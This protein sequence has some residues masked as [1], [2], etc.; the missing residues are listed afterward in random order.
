VSLL[1]D[2][3]MRSLACTAISPGLCSILVFD[4]TPGH[5][6]QTAQVYSQM[7]EVAN[8]C[9]VES[10]TLA[11]YETDDE[12]WGSFGLCGK[13]E[14]QL[15]KWKQGLLTASNN[16]SKLKLVIIPDLTRLSLAAARACVVLM[17]AETAHLER[18]GQQ[19]QWKPNLCWLAACDTIED[20]CQ[21]HR[22]KVGMVSPHLLDRFAIRLVGEVVEKPDRIA[23][24]KEL[25]EIDSSKGNWE[26]RKLQALPH[27]FQLNLKRALQIYPTIT[28]SVL[29]RILDYAWGIEV[30][31]PRRE[32]ALAR[33][34]IANARLLGALAVTDVHVDIAA[35]MIGLQ[36]SKQAQKAANLNSNAITPVEVVEPI[37]TEV[38]SIEKP[39]IITASEPIYE[40]LEQEVLPPV[41]IPIDYTSVNPYP[42][43]EA[44]IE[45]EV[46]SLR[47]PSGSFKLQSA[48]RG[49]IVGVEK[50]TTLH[51]LAL[52]R[53]L[54][55]A[56]K[57]Q[58]I[59]QE[60]TNSQKNGLRQ[61]VLSPKDFY[62]YRRSPVAQQMLMLLIDHTCLQDCNWQ[63]ELLPYLSWAYVERASLCLIQVGADY[64]RNELQA[65][66]ITAQSILVPRINNGIEAGRGRATP[67]AHGLD[68]A[69]QTLRHALQHGRSRVNKVVLLVISDGRGNVPLEAS[70]SGK[71]V[72]PVG[73]KGVEDAFKVAA[74]LRV[75]DRVKI[76]LLNPQPKQYAELPLQ[77]AQALNATVVPIPL[78]IEEEEVE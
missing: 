11:T 57:F 71:I 22:N 15:L 73:N 64:V 27:E 20:G 58:S 63:E 19:A 30:Y 2:P 72:L 26:E 31:S 60:P 66:K 9:S 18:H 8:K 46:A 52:V 67:L 33:L 47:L 43:D 59:R 3:F 35:S 76:I 51:D 25:I 4:A 61:L 54:L 70:R 41:L 37:Q 74:Y 65:E 10:V 44:Y 55:E 69:L 29:T 16:D 56:A 12:L 1:T 28:S 78:V 13:S 5:L 68:L 75:L 45:R 7:L 42:E 6:K 24:I 53:T 32:I 48:T 17:G 50:A 77:L 49:V 40:S 36:Q 39:K 14:K 38:E 62:C 21:G 23:E 34:S